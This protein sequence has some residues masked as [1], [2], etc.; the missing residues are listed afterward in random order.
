M[1]SQSTG[2]DHNRLFH[3]A[4]PHLW[5]RRLTDA[6]KALQRAAASIALFVAAQLAPVVTRLLTSV[7]VD[8]SD[9]QVFYKVRTFCQKLSVIICAVLSLL[10]IGCPSAQFAVESIES[11]ESIF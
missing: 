8:V 3:S 9:V 5:L 2:V 6:A 4:P 7:P 10:E 11:M 1:L